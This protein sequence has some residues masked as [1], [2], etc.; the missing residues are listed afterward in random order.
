[1]VPL[2]LSSNCLTDEWEPPDL[3]SAPVFTDTEIMMK[4]YD[5]EIR[6]VI[7]VSWEPDSTDT[8]SIIFYQVLRQTDNDSLPTPITNIPDTITELPILVYQLNLSDRVKE[9]TVSFWIFAIDSFGRAGDTSVAFIVKLARKVDLLSPTTTLTDSLFSWGINDIKNLSR[10]NAFL[11]KPDT[12][13]WVSDTINEFIGGNY[14]K[15]D[16][17]LPPPLYPLETGEY[18]WGVELTI[19]DGLPNE[20][21]SI[22]IAKFTVE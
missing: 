9:H 5:N 22:T 2:L 7:L 15:F 3:L 12:T 11:W 18:F 21:K 19:V 4:L 1:M 16:Q 17:C 8:I 14:T 13:L 10:F 20:P 6:E